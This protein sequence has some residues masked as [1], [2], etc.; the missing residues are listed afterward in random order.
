MKIT[1]WFNTRLSDTGTDPRG[2]QNTCDQPKP[3]QRHQIFLISD[4]KGKIHRRQLAELGHIPS[5]SEEEGTF[6]KTGRRN[7]LTSDEQSYEQRPAVRRSSAVSDPVRRGGAC[8]SSVA[9]AGHAVTRTRPFRG[10][11]RQRGALSLAARGGTARLRFGHGE[12]R[13]GKVFVRAARMR[14]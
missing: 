11:P 4:S 7:G 2:S 9:R 8:D 13:T 12:R 3:A 10:P 1:S 5:S 6:G 14:E